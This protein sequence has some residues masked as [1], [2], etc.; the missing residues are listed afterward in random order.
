MNDTPE[1]RRATE[2]LLLA[3]GY[4]WQTIKKQLKLSDHQYVDDRQAIAKKKQEIISSMD[5]SEVYLEY[6][7][8][9]GQSIEDLEFAQE[10]ADSTAS[11]V[12]AIRSKE[13]IAANRIRVA[14]ELGILPKAPDRSEVAG[15]HHVNVSIENKAELLRTVAERL[16][17]KNS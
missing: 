5:P 14:Q 11:K 12:N 7:E 17:G 4:T 10:E 15:V 13:F 9:A 3:R 2:M 8:I 16:S 1:N 6:F